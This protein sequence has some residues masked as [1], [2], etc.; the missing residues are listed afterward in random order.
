MVDELDDDSDNPITDADV[1]DV[2]SKLT[3]DDI[4]ERSQA[5]HEAQEAWEELAFLSTPKI[6]CREC[7]ASGQ[8]HGGS[9]GALCPN[10]LGERMV[11]APGAEPIDMPDFRSL[12][13][14]IGAYGDAL[15]FADHSDP[16]M[17]RAL[18]AGSGVPTL[19]SI[20]ALKKD[21]IAKS[22]Q[23]Q[24][25]GAPG[26]FDPKQLPE[27]KPAKGLAGEGD[28]GEYDDAEL[29][30]MVDDA[31]DAEKARRGRR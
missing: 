17:R 20:T 12:R 6:P 22:R 10:C 16:K 21:A 30:E 15:A 26:V 23:L 1:A 3:E 18:P 29:D 8:V 27:P 4:R 9:F 11:A 13:A 31:K 24:I 2:V 25:G 19:E 5:L 28:L 7:G 14:A